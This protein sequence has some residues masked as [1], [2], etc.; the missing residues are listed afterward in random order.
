MALRGAPCA[1]VRIVGRASAP[2]LPVLDAEA[3]DLTGVTSPIAKRY[4]MLKASNT[5]ITTPGLIREAIS[6]GEGD[7]RG[8]C[9]V[10][11]LSQ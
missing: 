9:F 8:D 3:V 11:S 5:V 6:S 4:Y 2:A 7:K 1:L 10:A